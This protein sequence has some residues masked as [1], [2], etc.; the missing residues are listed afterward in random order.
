MIKV[1]Y[2][3]LGKLATQQAVQKLANSSFKT[4]QAFAVK[5]VTKAIRDGFFKMREEYQKEVHEKYCA[6]EET[7]AP[8][9]KAQLLQIP[10]VPKEGKEE[11]CK[12]AL[13]NFGKRILTLEKKKL[14]AELLFEVNEWSPRELES[15]EF[16]V[17]EPAGS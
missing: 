11:E 4:P 5:H 3:E 8:G 9:T 17:D 10:F 7:P 15:L 1:Q 2:D 14:S 13:D 16:L 6:K 12:L